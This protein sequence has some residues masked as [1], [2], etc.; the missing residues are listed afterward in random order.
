VGDIE[1]V[2]TLPALQHKKFQMI[3]C[4]EAW[5][6]LPNSAAAIR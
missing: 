6:T 1:N 4:I 2:A 5:H 3:L